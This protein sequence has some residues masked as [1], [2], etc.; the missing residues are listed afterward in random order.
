MREPDA[1]YRLDLFDPIRL[2][3]RH[4]VRKRS[5]ASPQAR[6]RSV[7]AVVR[8]GCAGTAAVYFRGNDH[9]LAG[10]ESV[11]LCKRLEGLWLPGLA[12]VSGTQSGVAGACIWRNE[13][14]QVPFDVTLT[15]TRNSSPSGVGK[16]FESLRNNVVANRSDEF[17]ENGER[18]SRTLRYRRG[19]NRE[20]LI[21]DRGVL[22]WL[23]GFRMRDTMFDA[24]AASAQATL[25]EPEG[26]Q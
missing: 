26:T 20:W 18:G 15:T 19:E 4:H 11:A 25:R 16:L 9:P 17:V 6:C 21:E 1:A 7:I 12:P 2:R 23:R 14:G 24:L 3:S 13:E 10:E 22:L 8:A 5:L